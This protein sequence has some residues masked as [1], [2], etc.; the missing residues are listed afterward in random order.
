[1]IR[2]R[3]GGDQDEVFALNFVDDE[4]NPEELHVLEHLTLRVRH[5]RFGVPPGSD[6]A[7]GNFGDTATNCC[8]RRDA[9]AEIAGL[10][11][12]AILSD[13]FT[14]D[15]P[16]FDAAS[17]P[18]AVVLKSDRMRLGIAWGD[19]N[20]AEVSAPRLRAA[21]RCAWCTRERIDGTFAA[22]FETITIDRLAAVGDYAINIAF[23]DGHARGI[24][25]W[26]Y[27]QSIAEADGRLTSVASGPP[28]SAQ[29]HGGPC[30]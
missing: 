17:V 18:E 1:M 3:P 26:A 30:E 27:L 13:H 15:G 12:A 7:A 22:S 10:R 9:R 2:N 28:A 6:Y 21:C 29:V 23:S 19:G 5:R 4:F 14:S 25:P 20:A 16:P 8:L 11:G 24:Y